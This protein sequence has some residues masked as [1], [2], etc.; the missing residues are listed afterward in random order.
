MKLT[1]LQTDRQ[2]G[3]QTDRIIRYRDPAL[4][5]MVKGWHTAGEGQDGS[6]GSSE[7]E[8]EDDSCLEPRG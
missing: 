2:A 5:G 4:G 3:R 8:E 1:D 6:V 7:K